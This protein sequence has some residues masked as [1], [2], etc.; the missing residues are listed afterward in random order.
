MDLSKTMADQTMSVVATT[1][2]GQ[3]FLLYNILG[4]GDCGSGDRDTL[5]I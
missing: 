3:I 5:Y 2:R 4:T 1:R